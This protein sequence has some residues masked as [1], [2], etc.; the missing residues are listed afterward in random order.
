MFMLAPSP[1]VS[2]Q[3][4]KPNPVVKIGS[5]FCWPLGRLVCSKSPFTN[6][7]GAAGARL[8]SPKLTLIAATISPFVRLLLH[9][10]CRFELQDWKLYFS[11]AIRFVY[12]D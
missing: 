1:A 10:S 8:T 6:R 3:P 7:F 2:V 12:A 4:G 5:P 9:M 11:P